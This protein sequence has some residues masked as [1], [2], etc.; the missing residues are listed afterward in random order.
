[1]HRLFIGVLFALAAAALPAQG[2]DEVSHGHVT[3]LA[4]AKVRTPELRAFLLSH[5]DEVLSGSWYP[6]WIYHARVL[7][8]G[9]EHNGYLDAVWTDL[10]TPSVRRESKYGRYLA[11]FFGAYAH[12]VEDRVL[13]NAVGASADEVGD[14]GRDDMEL[15][16]VDIATY[17]YLKRDF[18]MS[19]PVDDLRRVYRNNAY[20]HDG[21]LTSVNFDA[22]LREGLEKQNTEN[23]LLKLMSFLTADWARMKFPYAAAN[24]RKAPGGFDDN[25]SAVAAA[26]EAIWARLH[27]RSAPL[28]VFSLP[29]QNG[30]L[31]DLRAS[32]RFGQILI[33]SSRRIASARFAPGDIQLRGEK[34]ENLAVR[35]VSKPDEPDTRDV[36]IVLAANKPWVAGERYHLDVKYRDDGGEG[37][38][39]LD[40]AAPKQPTKFIAPAVSSIPFEFGVWTG[41]F[42]LGLAAML[43]GAPGIFGFAL[44]RGTERAEKPAIRVAGWMCRGFGVALL[45]VAIYV[46]ATDGQWLI[47]FLRHHH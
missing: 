16:M 42:L 27:G 39:A 33:V 46:L 11:H 29:K 41:S 24:M 13:D 3:E 38:Y 30:T 2:W 31:A 19:L 23:R 43:Y 5:R 34:G 25:A 32:T 22:T 12:V 17:G 15:G 14:H 1:M 6:D 45:I 9:R 8:R 36:A 26:W 4:I 37:R 28:F 18:S 35:I 44:R 7:H 10:Q 40:F 20:F 47:D 21:G